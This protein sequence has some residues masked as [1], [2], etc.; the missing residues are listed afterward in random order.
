MS[1]PAALG[2]GM[3][4]ALKTILADQPPLFVAM[5]DDL[6]IQTCSDLAHSWSQGGEM[7]TT[8]EATHG[9]V[10]ADQ[11]FQMMMVLTLA[12][13]QAELAQKD[14]VRA[15]VADRESVIPGQPR[16]RAEPMPVVPVGSS[17]PVIDTGHTDRMPNLLS[18]VLADPHTKEVAKR[19]VKT[20]ALFQFV[21][22]NLINLEEMGLCRGAL[23]DPAQMQ[24]ARE[25][26]MQCC[27][28]LGTERLGALLA[29]AKRW[30]RY[31][32]EQEVDVK[33]P[34]PYQ[35]AAFLRQVSSGGP[36]AGASMFQAMRWYEENFGVVFHT[37][38][39]LVRPFRFHQL[40][41]TGKQQ[42]ELEP[43]E[44]CNLVRLAQRS[45]GT[46]QIL[47]SFALQAAVSCI[48]FEQRSRY[49]ESAGTWLT[50]AC[51]QGK[52][53]KQGARPGYQWAM[54]G[55][56]DGVFS[57]TKVIKDFCLHEMLPDT[58][59]AWPAVSLDHEDLWQKKEHQPF[60]ARPPHEPQ[61]LPGD[62]EGHA[63]RSG[64]TP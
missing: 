44:F 45:Q 33:H 2:S 15:I 27:S 14:Q 61:P 43:W 32:T 55:L 5:L 8:Y 30:R 50:F 9:A 13:A 19:E 23:N 31:A 11:A 60:C 53:R 28:R 1:E 3:D 39:F 46:K 4:G 26:L 52:S 16:R 12:Q 6:G 37:S 64:Y 10:S 54:P 63:F 38:H 40:H 35:V 59:F 18:A 7:I 21:L 42:K 22:E 24:N 51:A 25:T 48:R 62:H 58:S 41:H 34:T 17:K 56:E 36:T 47:A 49:V 29:A 57:M 20:Q